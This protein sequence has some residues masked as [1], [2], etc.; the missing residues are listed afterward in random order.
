MSDLLPHNATDAERALSEATGRVV[1]VPIRSLWNPA[2]CAENLLP[3]LAWSVSVD[4]WNAAWT[5]SQKRGAIA[6][7]YGV[8]RY[9]GTVGAMNDALAGIGYDVGLVEW[10][11]KTPVASQYTFSL[12]VTIEQVGLAA[13]GYNEI[14][15]VALAVK[16]LRSQLTGIDVLALTSGSQ[17]IGAAVVS[18]EITNLDAEPD[19]VV[20]NEETFII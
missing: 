15:D 11:Q 10:F 3:W 6:A 8:H 16:N 9:K 7:S 13:G 14:R 18:G 2:T 20:V 4:E 12:V 5:V 17:W 1:P 19:L